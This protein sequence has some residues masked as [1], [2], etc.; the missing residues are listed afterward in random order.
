MRTQT[1]LIVLA[2]AVALTGPGAFAKRSKKKPVLPEPKPL[3]PLVLTEL[4]QQHPHRVVFSKRT[5][6][7]VKGVRLPQA[8][9]VLAGTFQTFAGPN[10][11]CCLVTSKQHGPWEHLVIDFNKNGNLTDDPKIPIPPNGRVKKMTLKRN[12]WPNALAVSVQGHVQAA[13]LTIAPHN[14]MTGIMK[15][16]REYVQW[17]APDCNMSGKVDEGDHVHLMV[18]KEGQLLPSEEMMDFLLVKG[19]LLYRGNTW[20]EV[21][22]STREKNRLISRT[23]RG[24]LRT[25]TLDQK[26]LAA[27]KDALQTVTLQLPSGQKVTLTITDPA[28]GIRVPALV[29][30]NVSVSIASNPTPLQ[31]AIPTLDMRKDFKVALNKPT[32]QA[33]VSQRAGSIHVDQKVIFPKSTV[34]LPP[35]KRGRVGPLVEIFA[36][37]EATGKP[38]VKGNM[39]YG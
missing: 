34:K 29:Y 9:V 16:G 28:R 14:A 3:T 25:L 35:L 11:H 22:V 36:G 30:K 1:T 33:S 5:S 19:N 39:E 32:L 26:G 7:L 38:I 31:F 6:D 10:V 23:Y 13:T 17:L 2:L 27:S 12:G 21:V 8:A 4:A 18:D 20:Y 37:S 24:P 15:F